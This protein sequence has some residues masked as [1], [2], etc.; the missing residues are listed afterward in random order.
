MDIAAVMSKLK[1]YEEAVTVTPNPVTLVSSLTAQR[2][3]L[4]IPDKTDAVPEVN[5]VG[6]FNGWTMDYEHR[7]PNAQRE[8]K[9]TVNIQTLAKSPK[10]SEASLIASA[11]HAALVTALDA[12][13]TLEGTCTNQ[14]L[15]SA[16][17]TRLEWAGLSFIGVDA[18][19]DVYMRDTTTVG[20]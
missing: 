13:L 12:H 5:P 17:L 14:E 15:R 10:L 11:F 6:F 2:A 4:Y 18:F 9:Y 16:R 8:Q 20:A 3:Y 7:L 19:L 1:T